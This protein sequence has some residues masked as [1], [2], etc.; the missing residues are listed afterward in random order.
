MLD[1]RVLTISQT[2]NGSLFTAYMNYL[3][4]NAM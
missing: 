1:N 4:K 3:L 2:P